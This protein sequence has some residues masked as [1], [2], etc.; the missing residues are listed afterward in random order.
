[1]ADDLVVVLDLLQRGPYQARDDAPA[2]EPRAPREL[3]VGHSPE[4]PGVAISLP[5]GEDR[6]EL[7]GNRDQA[8]R[9]TPVP[10]PPLAFERS[11]P[12]E[13]AA[14]LVS[15]APLL[16]ESNP[17]RSGVDVPPPDAR[18]FGEAHP[19]E[20]KQRVPRPTL[21]RDSV[22]AD[23]GHGRIVPI[24]LALNGVTTRSL[25]PLVSVTCP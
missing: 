5:L 7:V 2:M 25:R 1:V 6:A 15:F 21:E 22:V 14:A 8:R 3:G 19:R 11:V 23:Q 20:Q 9:S 13:R 24:G 10:C 4:G 12:R 17:T 16:G 18:S